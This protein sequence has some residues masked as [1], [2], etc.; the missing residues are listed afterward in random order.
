[1]KR[2]ALLM[3]ISACQPQATAQDAKK[4]GDSAPVAKV[5]AAIQKEAGQTKEK[6]MQNL[7]VRAPVVAGSWYPGTFD[8][9]SKEVDRLF[10]EARALSKA[11]P[12][13]A[14]A[15]VAPHAGYRFSGPTAALSVMQIDAQKTKRVIVMGPSHH[16]SFR[17]LSILDV[18]AYQTPLGLIRLDPAVAEMRK[19]PLVQSLERAHNREHAIEIEL[20][21]LQ[22]HLGSGFTIIPIIVGHLDFEEFKQASDLIRPYLDEETVIL[23]SSDFTHY[24]ANYGY[25]PFPVN[26][27][28]KQ[29]LHD[30]DFGAYDALKNRN[31]AALA[32]YKQRTGITACGYGP[33]MIMLNALGAGAEPS[34]LH[35][36]TSAEIM[37]DRDYSMSVSYFSIAYPREDGVKSAKTMEDAQMNVPESNGN[38]TKDDLKALHAVAMRA[39]TLAVKEGPSAIEKAKVLPYPELAKEPAGAF[40]TLKKHGQLRGCIGFI[41]PHGAL[42]DAITQNAMNAALK[43]PRFNPVMPEELAELTVEISVLSPLKPAT[44]DQIK[45]G[46]DG[47]VLTKGYRRSVFLPEVPIEQGWTLDQT[48]QHLSLK[49]GLPK[50]AYREGASF[51]IFTSQIYEA[52]YAEH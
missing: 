31:A 49:A 50:D 2:L 51:E 36:T 21:L 17:G 29:N 4:A 9:L 14:A 52:P 44:L 38:L 45:L 11:D 46:R 30:L 23:V 48:L 13:K 15:V 7:K 12:M 42:I 25:M 19:S 28:T 35:Y 47:I 16:A 41:E 5:P 10:V 27:Q 22:K 6:D 33:L 26:E 3:L 37:G 32:R 24:G 8:A 43:D 40:V 20:P 39:L 1:M 18:D 34:M